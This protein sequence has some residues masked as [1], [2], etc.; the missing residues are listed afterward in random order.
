MASALWVVASIV[1]LCAMMFHVPISS[2][3]NYPAKPVR[4]VVSGVAGSS[5]IT[6]RLIAPGLSDILGQQVVV[7]GREGGVVV[8]DLVAKAQPDGYTLLLNGSAMWLLP[9][10]RDNVPYGISHRYHW[11]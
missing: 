7:D 11:P 1:A 4:M 8:S 5:N 2:A 6:A 9:Y 3:Q 10:M